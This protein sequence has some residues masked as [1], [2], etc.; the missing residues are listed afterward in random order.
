VPPQS[1]SAQ[2]LL[3]DCDE[4]ALAWC[5]EA[6]QPTTVPAGQ[7]IISEG[8]GSSFFALISTGNV[9]VNIGAGTHRQLGPGDV[10]GEI[11][12]LLGEPRT[13]TVVA[14][15][16]V[17]LRRGG[18][19]EFDQLLSLPG[20]ERRLR[21]TVSQR[22][23]DDAS[24]IT[25]TDR[26]GAPILLRPL[27]PTDRQMLTAAIRDASVETIRM[28]FFSAASVSQRMI[29]YLVDIN[30]RDHFAWVA[31]DDR[32]RPLALARTIRDR[33]TPSSAE[34]AF[35]TGEAARGRG[36]ATVLLGA[37]GA[38]A[39]VMDTPDLVAVVLAENEPMRAVIRRAG[40]TTTRDEPGVVRMAFTA[41]DAA[42]LLGDD[43][44]S[45]VRSVASRIVTGP[46]DR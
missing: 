22:L 29:D 16:D 8:A 9:E 30:Y 5:N 44:G 7:T 45:A 34:V 13:A 36:L 35:A 38:T 37:L 18:L 33:N 12:L 25:T 28:R 41:D 1:V 43:V 40:A 4:P 10:I 31:C 19:A 20:V 17:A 2:G 26:N 3:A 11:G 15:S 42:A 24:P 46:W 27:L 39:Q 21:T 6:L 14:G 23:A 32:R